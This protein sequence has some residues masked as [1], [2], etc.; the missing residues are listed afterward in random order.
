MTKIKSDLT[1]FANNFNTTLKVFS[2]INNQLETLNTLYEEYK[3]FY[4]AYAILASVL[5]LVI[6]KLVT[7][8][9][10][11]LSLCKEYGQVIRDFDDF[12]NQ[13]HISNQD[14]QYQE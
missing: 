1:Y 12:R 3:V 4:V 13:R 8:T 9:C 7:L 5:I 11:I 2:K 14:R 6:M 10:Y